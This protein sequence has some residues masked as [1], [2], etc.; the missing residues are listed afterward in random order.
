MLTWRAPWWIYVVAAV[1][2]L[3]FLF[4][5]QQEGWGPANA[6]WIPSWPTLR[7]A[8]VVPGR[9]MDKAGLRTGDVLE[10]VNGL[11]LNG[12]P[13]WFVARAHFERNH[14]I[15][16]EIRRGWRHLSL[17][18][19]IAAPAWRTWNRAHFLGVVAFYFA[20][21]VLLLLAMLVGFS[22]P[23]QLSARLAALML[24]VGAVAEGYPS[25]GWAAALHHLPAVLAVP[26]CLATG[27]C[28][29]ASLVWLPFFATYPRPQPW[30]H[31]QWTLV[32]GPLVI[33]GLSMMASGI[34]MIYTPSILAR[35]WPL[36]LSAAPVRVIEDIAGVVPLL[37]LNV[38]PLYHPIVQVSFLELWL[39]ISVLYFGAGFLMLVAGYRRM[40]NGR[41]P[42]R[43]G[44][45]ALAFVLF[46][47]IVVHNVFT[48]NW[49]NWFGNPPPEL[50]SE[51]ISVGED[52]LFLL[53]P[54]T[55][56]YCVL[57]ERV[58]DEM[59]PYKAQPPSLRC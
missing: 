9:P 10:A 57:T 49:T 3:T 18:F 8:G 58:A 38:L 48:R 13:D 29:L 42:R 22:R 51:A 50:F 47:I 44:T 6:G 35:P 39:A 52:I 34:A 4:N 55:L 21:L 11:P 56:A 17:Q 45:L 19:V 12:M 15:N 59:D 20:R 41:E 16:L 14:P 25:S 2:V 23:Q 5:G 31:W 40:E 54:L 32:L 43:V 1:Y 36:V 46:A 33:L 30:Q 28:L 53:V 27:S 24:A 26:I 37:F 7:V